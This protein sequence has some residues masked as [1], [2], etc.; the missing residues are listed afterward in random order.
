MEL[1]DLPE[2]KSEIKGE[3]KLGLLTSDGALIE[4]QKMTMS[5]TPSLEFEN[6][7]YKD[8]KTLKESMRISKAT[9]RKSW[10]V[11][12]ISV[13]VM[14]IIGVIAFVLVFKPKGVSTPKEE[15]I[16]QKSI[17]LENFVSTDRLMNHLENFQKIALAH[18]NSRSHKFGFNASL[19]YVKKTLAKE[20]PSLAQTIQFF[21]IK[22][23]ES[24]TP[25][26]LQEIENNIVT[27]IVLN[28]DFV[29]MGGY[30]GSIQINGRLNVV[31]N[32]G[33][34]LN[35]YPSFSKNT[36][37]ALVK[38]GQCTFAE[39]IDAASKSGALA[40]LIYNDGVGDR[41]APFRG[42]FGT[43][44]EIP[45]FSLS[46]VF[47]S[48]LVYKSNANVTLKL[49]VNSTEYTIEA[50]NLCAETTDSESE[51][52]ILI[53]SHLDSVDAGPGINDNGSGSATNLELAI[54]TAN[55][56]KSQ[57]NRVRFCWWGGEELGLL[58]STYYVSQLEDEEKEAI[59]A[60]INLDMVASPN[61][62][63]G[64]YNGTMAHPMIRNVSEQITSLFIAFFKSKKLPYSMT[65][66]DGRSDYGPFI[67]NET[68]IAAGGLFTGAE[69]L[70]T[71][72]ERMNYGGLTNAAYDPCYHQVCDTIHN[73]DRVALT[74]NAMASAYVLQKMMQQTNK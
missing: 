20:A 49:G 14:L 58:G 69:Q 24:R 42:N 13:C 30:T 32:F 19:D 38:R 17:F 35:D 55:R 52:T 70:K 9:Q 5:G 47:G 46:F 62:F 2:M 15:D 43:N 33:C 10:I 4:D 37:F 66:F 6:N 59:H 31:S 67:A 56:F 39:K 16:K 11:L 63:Y 36:T 12:G 53:G 29:D 60:N 22:M 7:K 61:K 57:Q 26:L 51:K 23:F 45:V 71:D 68:L 41:V 18:G 34:A 8:L 44:V 73:I 50:A 48:L 65:E 21:P 54:Q 1:K 74:N 28:R 40:I 3:A 25:P 27:N 72:Q 64:I